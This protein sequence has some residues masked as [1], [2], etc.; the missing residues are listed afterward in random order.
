[1][2]AF[3]TSKVFSKNQI[4]NTSQ[5][6]GFAAEKVNNLIDQLYGNDA[7]IIGGNNLKNGPDRLVNGIEIQTKYCKSATETI[8]ALFEKGTF[9]YINSSGNAMVTE[10]PSDQYKDVLSLM[11]ERIRKGK[12]PGVKDVRMAEKLIRRG[13]ISYKQALN[14]T[15]AGK[16]D[17][18][19]YDDATGAIACSYVFEITAAI[20]CA[21]A[22]WSGKSLS[23]SLNI[24]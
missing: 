19:M 5:G 10:V 2:G 23:E 9:R 3:E 20:T 8:S 1:M 12:V 18:L 15:Q 14:T 11:K 24:S 6:H 4:H 17:S 22:L 16:L 21:Q 7:F 13:G